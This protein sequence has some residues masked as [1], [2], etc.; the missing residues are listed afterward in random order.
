LLGKPTL[1]VTEW[2]SWSSRSRRGTSTSARHR[3][4][5]GE[6]LPPHEIAAPR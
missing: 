4:W 2:K 1:D 5:L 6:G 3:A